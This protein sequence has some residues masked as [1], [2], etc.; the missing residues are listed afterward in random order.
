[1][2]RVFPCFEHETIPDILP[3]NISWRYY[4]TNEKSIW[5]APDSINHICQADQAGGHC[6]GPLWKDNVDLTPKDVLKDISNCML[7]GVTWAIPAGQN[8]DHAKTNHGGGPAWVASIVNA[9]GQSKCTN[10]DGSSYWNST[11]IFLTWDDWGGWYD[12]EAPETLS[13]AEG[14]YQ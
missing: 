6:V 12:H 11:A 10:P 4:T 8:S 14:D 13:G 1:K 2:N 9:I 5:T 7:R 3:S